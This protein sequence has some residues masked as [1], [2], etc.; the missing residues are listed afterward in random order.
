MKKL[1]LIFSILLITLSINAQEKKTSKNKTD[2]INS[3]LVPLTEE[4]A[5]LI[6]VKI[7]SRDAYQSVQ[8]TVRDVLIQSK[9]IPKDATKINIGNFINKNFNSLR[10]FNDPTNMHIKEQH[11]YERAFDG[12]V[13]TFFSDIILDEDYKVNINKVIKH[14]GKEF[15]LLDHINYIIKNESHKFDLTRLRGLRDGI[16]EAIEYSLEEN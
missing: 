13:L 4:L 10:C 3:D 6:C 15:T 7:V 5:D 16:K 2:K 12:H 8:K 14:N 9:L 11:V 1:T